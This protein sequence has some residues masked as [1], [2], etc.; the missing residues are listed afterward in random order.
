MQNAPTLSVLV[1]SLALTR[2]RVV[3]WGPLGS[4]GLPKSRKGATVPMDGEALT[5]DNI[6]A[7]TVLAPQVSTAFLTRELQGG[8]VAT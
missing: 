6:T 2:L 1:V 3:V 5:C 7:P 8:G 4:R